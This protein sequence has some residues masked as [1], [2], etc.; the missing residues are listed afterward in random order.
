MPLLLAP[1][2]KQL[3]PLGR[4]CFD[5]MLKVARLLPIIVTACFVTVDVQR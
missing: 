4:Y 3:V 1:A 5:L 2:G